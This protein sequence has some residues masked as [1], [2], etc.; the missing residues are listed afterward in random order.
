MNSAPI[1][2]SLE[3]A[4]TGG[5]IFLGRGT[6]ALATREGDSKVSHSN[7]LLSDIN[8]CLN[9]AGLRLAD[10]ELFAC[11][12]GPGSFTGLRIGIATL[13]AFAA[14]LDRPCVGVPTLN[15][16]AQGAGE[17]TA[18]VALLSAGRGEVFA[19]M[20][21]VS[22]NELFELDTAAHLSPQ[23]LIERYQEFPS[24]VW[25]GPGATL[26]RSLLQGHA[27]QHAIPFVERLAQTAI[28]LSGWQIAPLEINLARNVSVLA[29][30]LFTAGQLQTAESLRARYVRPSDAEINQTWQ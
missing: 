28:D 1:I 9:D 2:L 4:T 21:S 30:R 25:A 10:I 7:S 26:H 22:A 3:T 14:T 13:K 23:K 11:V 17:S 24:L 6:D 27:A 18:T 16:I 20:F 15:A 8:G 19:Q 12:S 29:L 5:S